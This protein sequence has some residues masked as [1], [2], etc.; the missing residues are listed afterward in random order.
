MGAISSA[1]LHLEHTMRALVDENAL[2]R[3]QMEGIAGRAGLTL[4]GHG[5]RGQA[6]RP[7]AMRR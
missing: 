5:G 6:A 7:G 4:N 3:K 1:L 2:L